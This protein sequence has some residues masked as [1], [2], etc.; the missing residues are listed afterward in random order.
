MKKILFVQYSQTGQ[1]TN[2]VNSVSKPL[3]DSPHCDVTILNIAP[4]EPYPYPWTFFKFFDVFPECVYLD[5]P[6]L[7]PIELDADERFDLVII[8]YQVWFLAP[9]LP[10][11][12]FIKSDIARAILKDTP[13]ITLIGCRNMWAMAQ[14]TM[15][16]MLEK[17]G[18]C[19]L[20]NVVLVDQGSALA[21]FIT[22][23]RWLL[24]GKKGPFWG[25]PEAGVS[26]A[27]ISNACRFGLAIEAALRSDQERL[28]LPLLTGLQAVQ[29]EVSHIK[30]EKIGYR[31]F[32]IWGKLVRKAGQPGDT[33]RKP[34]LLI[35]L[36]FLI[37]MII[38]VVPVNMVL[39][40]LLYPFR[41]KQYL[42]MKHQYELPSGSDSERL[43]SYKC[44][45]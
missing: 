24:T 21:S 14:Q 29:A 17:A 9:A 10:I 4:L 15:K 18:A 28:Q 3:I 33:L 22:T 43:D 31:S 41:K 23:P 16:Q 13:V 44:R 39:Q 20:D 27:D 32:R 6:A 42:T 2:I 36:V 30:S 5:P 35:Y 40:R 38:T 26:D 7:A 1:L 19:L 12:G 37:I 34:I 8:A 25:F 45:K 11:T